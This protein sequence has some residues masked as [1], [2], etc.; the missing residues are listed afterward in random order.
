M[1]GNRLELL[2]SVDDLRPAAGGD[3][4]FDLTARNQNDSAVL[5][6]PYI[7]AIADIDIRVELS[8]GLEFK[9]EQAWTRPSGFVTS[10]Q[11]ATWQPEAVDVKGGNTRPDFREIEIKAQLT[12]DT[13]EEI[14]LEERCITAR[15]AGSKPPPSPD[16]VRGSLKQCLGDDPPV[17]LEEGS[18]AFLTSFPCIDDAHT[19]AHQCE[20][21]PGVA[22]AARLPSRH[23]DYVESDDFYANLRSRGVGRTDELTG[24]GGRELTAF[25]DPESVFI[26]VKDPEGRVRDTHA[27]SV[28]DVSWQTA[29]K[30]ISGKNRAVDGVTITYTRKDIKDASAWN[31]LG[32]RVLTV[33]RADGTTPGKVKI[34]LN[35]SGNQFFD[36]S[37][38]TTTKNA[39]PINTVS[40]SV[41]QYFAE[42]ETLGTYFIDYSLTLTHSETTPNSYTDSG[43]YTFHVGPVAELEVRD[44]GA[45]PHAPAG[46]NAL[47][48]LAANNG[49]DRSLGARV[50]GLP[51]GAEVLYISQGTYD[52]S[53]GEWNTG[54]LGDGDLLRVRGFPGHAALVLDAGATA[55]ASVTIKNSVDYEV[56]IDSSGDDVNAATE[57]ACTATTGNT[58]HTTPVYDYDDGNNTATITARTGAASPATAHSNPASITVEWTGVEYLHAYP[59]SHY[60]VQWSPTGTVAGDDWLSLVD[61]VAHPRYVD[62]TVPP[63]DTRYY[64]VRAVNEAESEGPWSAVTPGVTAELSAAPPVVGPP[65]GAD[66]PRNARPGRDDDD[67]DDDEKEPEVEAVSFPASSAVREVVE[68]AGPGSPVGGPVTVASD[69]LNPVAYSLEGPDAHRFDIDPRTGQIT[70]GA[71]TALAF[72][73]GRAVFTVEVVATPGSGS[74]VR[75]TVTIVVTEDTGPGILSG[76]VETVL[77]GLIDVGALDRVFRF[78]NE[79]KEWRWHIADPAFALAN[80]LAALASGDLVWIKVAYSITVDILGT[81]VELTCINPGTDDQDCWNHVAIP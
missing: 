4:D 66:P 80:N 3:V 13:L 25:V 41:V 55:T 36:L 46:R 19:D 24:T 17:L 27:H 73:G 57:S 30:E 23:A 37:S 38:G 21:V 42:F 12:S 14:P 34:R 45:S 1:D 22:V 47:T 10:G 33:T 31:S 71:G 68:K 8:K 29:R 64:R 39:F 16:Y 53:A 7:N 69:P 74:P 26:Q 50:T 79:T 52:S 62:T 15:V 61:D 5:A 56:C 54:E 2:L 9:S 32:P 35:S 44:G 75:T 49:P 63:G 58:W 40:T 60:E 78:D 20:S 76:R 11:S 77:A 81:P 51:T 70:V 65:G 59:V 6:S 28:S 67:D 43:R 18:A 48:I 72:G